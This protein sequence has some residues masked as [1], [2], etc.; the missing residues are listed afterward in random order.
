LEIRK[1]EA[2]FAIS[3]DIPQKIAITGS[4][5]DLVIHDMVERSKFSKLFG[6]EAPSRIKTK[7]DKL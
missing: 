5:S 3:N 1:I 4:I 6:K 2:K 7:N